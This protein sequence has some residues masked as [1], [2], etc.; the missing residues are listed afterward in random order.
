[1]HAEASPIPSS[2]L[3]A[4]KPCAGIRISVEYRNY[5]GPG[6]TEIG[7]LRRRLPGSILLDGFT[8]RVVVVTVDQSPGLPGALETLVLGRRGD[9]VGIVVPSGTARSAKTLLQL[10][11]EELR[12]YGL[13]G[14]MAL[15]LLHLRGKVLDGLRG[16][17]PVRGFYSTKAVAEHYSIPFR[18]C[19]DINA[20]DFL[21]FVSDELNPDVI[22]SMVNPQIFKKG[23]L[24]LPGLGCINVHP[25]LLPEYRGPASTFWVLACGEAETGVTV[26]YMDEKID[27]G[28]I[29][30]QAKVSIRPEDTPH[31]I[32]ARSLSLGANL[33]L[34]ALR[35]M[36]A[37]T[38]AAV[39]NDGREATYYSLP[40][41][42][43]ARKL[44]RRG[45]TLV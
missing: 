7:E 34:R 40:T 10:L 18:S 20:P 36:E 24:G 3:E 45:R 19:E 13:R 41:V 14:C 1:L 26:H 42:E 27:N 39:P 32:R 8:V 31:S 29:I 33:A 2:G 12:F 4:E 5:A 38:V 23:I 9:I 16:L 22:V 25:S 11:I 17:L 30:L 44:R 37:G 35:Q 21:E 28:D 6:N 15:R 43:D